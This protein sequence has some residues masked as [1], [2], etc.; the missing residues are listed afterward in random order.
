MSRMNRL[1]LLAI[2]KEQIDR[3]IVVSTYSTATDW[4]SL[5]ERPLNYYSVGAMGLASSHGLGLA[6]ARPERK[7]IVLDGDGSL[8]MNLSSLVTIGKVA[9]RNF[10][11]FVFKNES[12]EA[13]GGHPIPNKDVDFEGLARSARYAHAETITELTSF[14]AR[15]PVLMQMQGP[16][17]VCL[18]IEQGPLGRRDYSDIY[19]AARRD[20]L[21][22]ALAAEA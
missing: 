10:L 14:A 1:A 4:S 13:N 22:Q 12:Y 9:P 7:I 5:S 2:L 11:H 17:F 21:R 19:K 3:E 16:V 6:L 20:A 15:L 8:L 18:E